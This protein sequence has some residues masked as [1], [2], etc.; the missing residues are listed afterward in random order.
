M[1]FPNNKKYYKNVYIIHVELDSD[2]KACWEK[3][4][5]KIFWF[6]KT[7]SKIINNDSCLLFC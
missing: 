2:R 3:A 5:S 1:T 7:S 4:K 6:L